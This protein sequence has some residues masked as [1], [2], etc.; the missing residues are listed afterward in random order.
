MTYKTMPLPQMKDIK[1]IYFV[2][3]KGVGVA[4]LAMIAHDAGIE[5]QG[6]DV[7]QEFI[8]DPSLQ[9]IKVTLDKG[10]EISTITDFFGG[11]KEKSLV[12]TTG[13]HKGF[14]NPQ[15]AWAKSNGITVITQGQALALFMDGEI[16]DRNFK[17]VAV[18]GSHG[19]TTITALL[20]TT[21]KAYGYDPS[22]S[23][24]TGEV[25]PL[26]SPGHLGNGDYFISE[27]DEYASEPVYDR[28]PKFLYIK[29]NY[30]IFNNIDF[31]HPD[32]FSDTNAIEEAFIQFAENIQSH[33]K[34]LVNGDDKRLLNFK[35]K[36]A[37]DIKIITYGEGN[38]NDYV[39]SQIVTHG[40][41]SRF[42]VVKKG[43]ELGHFELNI[44][45]VHNAKNSL[46]VIGFLTE[47]GLDPEKIRVCLREF[48]G[49][50]RR[51]EFVGYTAGKAIIMDDY[52]HHPL[53]ITTTIASIKEAYEGKNL[54][55]IFQPHTYSRTKALL[56]DFGKS[57]LGAD[58]LI[59]LP[60]FKSA[61]DTEKDTISQEEYLGAF[62]GHKSVKFFEKSDDMVEYVRQNFASSDNVI[63]TIGA[64]DVY[65]S[66]YLLK[67]G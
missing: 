49:T 36:I 47:I 39:I 57:F 34:L 13:A 12:I 59:L 6:S 41:G 19:K 26:G 14:D 23:I 5:I 67:N 2:G 25:F 46:A 9:K 50:K 66:G 15:V 17:S 64:G 24:G 58:N 21:L 44:P 45:G 60:I 8:T 33:G 53:E 62:E 32:L 27:A 16:F 51:S 10:F 4:P 63:L 11:I 31:D 38:Q 54:T 29:P 55:V 48:K 7:D 61:R 3:I 1:K 40:L 30:A 65:K 22:Y 43:K 18:S 37:K 52:G 42:N 28:I 20:A 35:T 56:S